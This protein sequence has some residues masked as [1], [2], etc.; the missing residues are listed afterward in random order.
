MSDTIDNSPESGSAVA[1]ADAAMPSELYA[2]G[3][4]RLKAREYASAQ[5]CFEKYLEQ[6]P[7]DPAALHLLSRSLYHQNKDQD[8]AREYLEKAARL[9]PG[10]LTSYLET[11]GILLIQQARY[12]EAM[13]V[14]ERALS[15][16]KKT[17][18]RHTA[19]LKFYLDLVKKK[20]AVKGAA[21]R[22]HPESPRGFFFTAEY[23]HRKMKAPYFVIPSLI[24]HALVLILV[25][26]LSTHHMPFKKPETHTDFTYV[27][28]SQPSGGEASQAAGGGGSA[29]GRAARASAP[30]LPAGRSEA[31]GQA[32]APPK[33]A[34]VEM[35]NTPAT[36]S[37][38]IKEASPGSPGAI[39][40]KNIAAAMKTGGIAAVSA[41]PAGKEADL[42]AV[43]QKFAEANAEI[44]IKSLSAPS[45]R[46][47][48]LLNRNYRAAKLNHKASAVAGGSID[49]AAGRAGKGGPKWNMEK[50]AGLQGRDFRSAIPEE[51]AREKTIAMSAPS[52]RPTGDELKSLTARP[53]GISAGGSR[54]VANPARFAGVKSLTGMREDISAYDSLQGEMGIPVYS[55][56]AG[57]GAV[58]S[59]ERANLGEGTPNGQTQALPGGGR[60]VASLDRLAGRMFASSA[61]SPGRKT[62]EM[63]GARA[64]RRASGSGSRSVKI[65][66]LNMK[67]AFP[68]GYASPGIGSPGAASRGGTG[69]VS[70]GISKGIS[71]S[72]LG[73]SGSGGTLGGLLESA[74]EKISGILGLR[75]RP[76]GPSGPSA[77]EFKRGG[78]AGLAAG[79][80]PGAENGGG[81]GGYGSYGRGAGGN[82]VQGG[83]AGRQS[84]WVSAAGPQKQSSWVSARSLSGG[85]RAAQPGGIAGGKLFVGNALGTPGGRRYASASRAGVTP[86]SV[87]RSAVISSGMLVAEN[88]IGPKVRIL[89]PG[90]GS[91][92]RLSQTIK[93]VV[94]DTRVGNATLT[95]NNNSQVI[96]VENGRFEATFSLSRGRN[97]VTVMAFDPD[98]NVGKDS[99]TLDYSGSSEGAPVNVI[100][101]KDGQ[102]FDVSENCVITVKGT[103]GDPDVS[104]AKLILNG[105]PMDIVVNRGYFEQKVALMEEQNTI[106]IEAVN[107]RGQTTHSPVVNVGTVN[108]K[109]KDILIILTWDKPHADF[110]LH[111]YSPSG[112]HTFYK[113]PNIYESRNAI[114]GG[115]LE[116]DAKGNFGPEVFD[117]GHAERGIYTVRSNYFYSGGD[118]DAHS[119]ITIILYGDNPSRRI[120][121]V[122]GPYLQRDTKDGSDWGP[123]IKFKMPEGIFLDE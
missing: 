15:E 13:E 113:Q 31:G 97:T 62:L 55:Q 44:S 27:Q 17:D 112:G 72:A 54:Q 98:G 33:M 8:K 96:S 25:S 28:L 109:P 90:S 93:G 52:F 71:R 12:K 41:M 45:K 18:A 74:S 14:F 34:K 11:Q 111:V 67:S 85:Y 107:S 36:A 120:V 75:G 1:Q 46:A 6:K 38:E 80:R 95:V 29:T 63:P 123:A 116:Q 47:E 57:G 78:V 3:A 106:Q 105:N 19:A 48:G 76:A 56:G 79:L 66:T 69:G 110:D 84:S 91:T 16:D 30:P 104:R 2:E 49:F 43:R 121:R 37:P 108:V 86:V 83:K 4:R 88:K 99:I 65:R 22:A 24:V 117:Q 42:K 9:D 61:V 5:A 10:S 87:G 122:F 77:V 26:Y 73:Q 119:K 39:S 92:D 70:A 89:S 64:G 94:S 81:R 82:G 103:I 58:A 40:A 102:V 20:G 32:P 100:Y 53:L 59:K 60:M 101:P 118:G 35:K 7:D 23:G 51:L 50:M 114:P 21:T 115:R 68:A